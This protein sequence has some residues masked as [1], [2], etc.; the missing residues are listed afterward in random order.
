MQQPMESHELRELVAATWSELKASGC[1]ADILWMKYRLLGGTAKIDAFKTWLRGSRIPDAD[2]YDVMA[3]VLNDELNEAGKEMMLPRLVLV[4]PR[5]GGV[6]L[7]G[8]E[9][10][11]IL[12]CRLRAS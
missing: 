10:D 5:G 1:S 12:Y 2:Q 9:S 4:A 3:S 8:V 6:P 11:D 7:K